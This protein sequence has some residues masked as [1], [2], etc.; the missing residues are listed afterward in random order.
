M[1]LRGPWDAREVKF[2][3]SLR[4][5]DN[6]GVSCAGNAPIDIESYLLGVG[7]STRYY[8]TEDFACSLQ[9]I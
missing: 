1:K 2:S 8:H 5:N 6:L 7:D 4:N 3:W 9:S